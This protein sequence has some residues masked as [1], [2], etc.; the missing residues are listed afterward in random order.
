[1]QQYLDSL[2]RVGRLAPRTLF[3]GH[4]PAVESAV[5]KLHEYVEHRLWREE[6]IAKAWEAGLKEPRQMLSEVYSDVPAI[7][8]PLAERQIL[9]HLARLRC[10]GRIAN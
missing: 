7:A 1:M 5:E 10:L 2:E 6:K 4:G 9:A 8:Y 3:P